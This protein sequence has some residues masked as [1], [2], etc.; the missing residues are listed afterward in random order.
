[1]QCNKGKELNIEREDNIYNH[2]R[3]NNLYNYVC[4]H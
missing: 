3:K 1:M 4:S 2:K